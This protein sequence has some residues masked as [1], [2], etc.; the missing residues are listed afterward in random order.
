MG[1]GELSRPDA[2]LSAIAEC[3]KAG[4][5][6]F[7]AEH[8]FGFN[9]KYFVQH[10]GALYPAK[11][12][13][14]VAYGY[15]FPAAGSL[16]NGQL[17]GGEAA[18]NAALR[19]LGFTVVALPR[20]Q[21]GAPFPFGELPGVP[22]G[23]TFPNRQ[24]L[25]KA[26]VHRQLQ[27]GITGLPQ[28]GAESIVLSGGYEDDEDHGDWILYTGQGGQV[29]GRHVEDQKL[30]AGN[31]ALVTSMTNGL[32]VRVIRAS[33]HKSPYSPTHGLVYSGL[34]RV[35]D[36]WSEPGKSGFLV[37]RYSLRELPKRATSAAGTSST[38]S[39][40][41][42]TGKA[43][44]GRATT[45]TQRIVRSSP[46]ADFVK[47][48]H[49]FKCQICGIRIPTP[50]G[51]YAEAAHI[52]A[53]GRPHGGPDEVG[54]VLCLCPNHHVQFDLGVIV[55]NDDFSVL[56]LSTGQ[57]EGALRR[58]PEHEIALAHIRYHRDHYKS[59]WL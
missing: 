37:W 27:G 3:E 53:L 32:P 50:T 21:Q 42:P 35:E 47:R 55:I 2:V 28:Y 14:A 5:R 44:P 39:A 56:D 52:R 20:P 36:Y 8:Q 51:A 54:N 31:A 16:S 58:L 33:T 15:Q 23:T 46:V 9:I 18:A 25:H 34:F 57:V 7:L 13:A 30:V 12:I 26:G 43:A 4:E 45:T 11:A 48:V 10:D 40:G 59:A 29:N 19:A 41:V 49:D 6:A 1:I 38:G 22:P 24:A 17:S